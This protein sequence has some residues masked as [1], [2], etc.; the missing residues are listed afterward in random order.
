MAGYCYL[1]HVSALTDPLH[2]MKTEIQSL[3]EITMGQPVIYI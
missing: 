1:L 2:R 3:A